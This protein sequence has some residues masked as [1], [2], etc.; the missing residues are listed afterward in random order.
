MPSKTEP[1]DDSR[2]LNRTEVMDRLRAYPVALTEWNS[3]DPY[4]Q[5]GLDPESVP[6]VISG[7]RRWTHQYS[8]AKIRLHERKAAEVKNGRFVSLKDVEINGEIVPAGTAFLSPAKSVEPFKK[9]IPNDNSK[10]R[11]TWLLQIMRRPCTLLQGKRL[12]GYRFGFPGKPDARAKWAVEQDIL[13]IVERLKAR[14]P[15]QGAKKK[16]YIPTALESF[17]GVFAASDSEPE[18]L[19]VRQ[20]VK[21]LNDRLQKKYG[22][23]VTRGRIYHWLRLSDRNRLNNPKKLP[24]Y[25]HDE[26]P[27]GIPFKKKRLP[28]AGDDFD[29]TMTKQDVNRLADTIIL[30]AILA[31]KR[32]LK[33]GEEICDEYRVKQGYRSEVIYWLGQSFPDRRIWV[34]NKNDKANR[35][36]EPARGFDKKEVDRKLAGRTI[37][38]A[39]KE[40]W[41]DDLGER[42]YAAV[43]DEWSNS[44]KIRSHVEGPYA[45]KTVTVLQALCRTGRI[46]RDPPLSVPFRPSDIRKGVRW[47]KVNASK[48]LKN[49]QTIHAGATPPPKPE[50]SWLP[51]DRQKLMLETMLAMEA[52]SEAMR[53]PQEAIVKGIHPKHDP[54]NYKR[55]FGILHKHGLTESI[56][57][58]DGGVW[59]TGQGISQAG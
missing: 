8:E 11:W 44:S 26:F 24:E 30:T 9:L 39:A 54:N 48:S 6:V 36:F 34:R 2:Q 3:D 4:I 47:R 28:N 21:A 10:H 14:T 46:E 42:V 43:S 20:I 19:K 18:R 40:R 41:L 7:A 25:L 22:L 17:N 59:L 31:E 50:S 12:R 35:D 29:Y 56:R 32:K 45:Y 51:T 37:L 38:E 15:K 57:G 49:V 1:Q 53:Q 55:D 23:T 5:E 27:A 13:N 16:R 58:P 33:T 52:T